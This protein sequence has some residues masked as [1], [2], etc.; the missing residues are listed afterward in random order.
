MCSSSWKE[1]CSL[2]QGPTSSDRAVPHNLEAE[3]ALLGSVLLDNSAL[4][5]AL[6]T[7]GR[8]D[9]F[10]EAHRITFSKMVVISENNRT[11]D[12][13]TLSEELSKDGQIDKAGGAAYLAALTD[14]VPIGTSVAVSEYCRIV[15]E[16]AVIRQLINAA[17][18]VISR[19]I[20]GTDDPATLLELAHSQIEDLRLLD[21]RVKT[22]SGGV[23]V[24][25]K[26]Q[27]ES[28]KEAKP[29][30]PENTYPLIPK[31]AWTPHA[32][33]Y[34]RAHENCTEGSDNWHYITFYTVMGALFGRT[35]GNRMGSMI[36][37]NLYSVLIGQIGGDG[38][39]TVAD[40]GVDFIEMVDEKVYIPEVIDS[41]PGFIKEWAEY[42]QR[43][44]V[45]S[46]HRA[47]L[48][49]PEIRTFLDTAEQSGTRSVSPMLL[50]HYG[51]R[52]SLDNTS[53]ATPAHIP[54]PHLAVLACGAKRFIGEIPEVDLINGL[55]RRLCCVPGDAKGPSDDPAAPDL[56]ILVPLA[57]AVKD[58]L[59]FYQT[60][61][62]PCQL[63]L[64]RSAAKL[65]KEWYKTY[66]KRKRGDDLFAAL[67]NGDR[68]TCR[69]IALINAGLDKQLDYIEDRHL[70]PAMA[71]VEFL[72]ECRW[73]IFSEHG[74]NP[75]VEIEKKIM[76]LI[77]DPPNR[78]SKRWVQQ[79][80]RAIDT[81]TFNDRVKYMT[82]E[83]G[84]LLRHEERK[85]RLRIFLS[86]AE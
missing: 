38:K 80:L 11:I 72:Y 79:H 61:K 82:M 66:W 35:L 20:E 56:E 57:Q 46:N 17:N 19:C 7:V 34:R 27:P 40:F 16:K 65:W 41:K 73:P 33:L 77:P 5:L 47:L 9:F 25:G 32:E 1:E 4:K 42:N 13:V 15:K 36:Y 31:A 2:T 8:D 60:L 64:S 55:G 26:A 76:S 81:K 63:K 86:R 10:S 50:T 62:I 18:N 53:I 84:P 68:V 28:P 58:A 43:E 39:D 74:A 70:E 21:V 67:N 75:Y 14:G 22:Q 59:E 49:L 48:R 45:V 30:K 6:E 69:K 24:I 54:N 78:I 12:L 29:K 3:R 85:G 23:E 44:S 52:R 51:P 37:G 83:D 71:C